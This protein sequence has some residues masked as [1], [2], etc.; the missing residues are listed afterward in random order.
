MRPT[1]PAVQF[2]DLVSHFSGR[3]A[4]FSRQVTRRGADGTREP[5]R[6]ADATVRATAIPGLG[7]GESEMPPDAL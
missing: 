3:T 5:G 4:R 1:G 2:M 6:T 7:A